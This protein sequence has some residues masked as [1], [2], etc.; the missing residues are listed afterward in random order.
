MKVL[1]VD[2]DVD[3]LDVTA[4]ALRREGFQ[5]ITATSGELAIARWEAAQPDVIVLDVGLPGRNGLDVCRTI[6][7]AGP[8]PIILL[9]AR[10]DEADIVRGF[11]VGADDYIVKPFSPRLLALRI[12]AVA[13]RAS[14]RA[15]VEEPVELAVG[16]LVLE[17]E[18]HQVQVNGRTV[19]LTP[20]EFRLLYLLASNAG[21]VVQ[22]TRLADYVWGYDEGDAAL[23][24]THC[25]H[26]R[27]KLRLGPGGPAEIQAVPRVGYR[28]TLA[29]RPAS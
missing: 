19:R 29:P 27:K 5:L 4:Y 26:I 21:R 20:I 12:R 25:S 28:L 23:L 1:L 3:L 9:T 15:M 17:R 24:K 18:S 10:G 13:R 2:D 22:A 6:R 16:E 14:P 7:R 8:T 11:G